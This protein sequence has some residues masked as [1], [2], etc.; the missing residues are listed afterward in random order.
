[1]IICTENKEELEINIGKGFSKGKLNV[2]KSNEKEQFIQQESIEPKNGVIKISLDAKCIYSI[3]TTSG[4]QKGSYKISKET[5]FPYLED[6]E[7]RKSGDLPKYHS[8]QTGSFEIALREDGH[9]V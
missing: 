2:W 5:A 3:T 9:S 1:M 7:D 4:Q 8:D 6:Y